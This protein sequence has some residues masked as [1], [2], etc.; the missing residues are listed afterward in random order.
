M[1]DDDTL[2]GAVL[3]DA[4]DKMHKAVA[5]TQADFS[6]VR[7]GR[8]SPGFVE[9]LK[10][11]YYGTETPLKQLAGF[12]VPEARLLVI[13]PYDKSSIKSI[14]KA[15]QN[16]DLG[17]MPSNDGAVIRLT[18]PALTEERRKDL[19]KMVHHKAED[20][21][22]AVRNVRRAARK[23]LDGLEHDG[24]IS[25]D[26]LERAEKDL[27]KVTHDHIAEIDRMVQHKEAE[28]LEV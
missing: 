6:G 24:D 10:I 13:T 25:G 23:D 7:T 14:E 15:I 8:A 17:I 21:R 11:D 22:V 5:H 12:N 9:N 1:A 26:D 2:M 4:R 3:D 27:E 19:V 16:S 28:L 18:F 20:G